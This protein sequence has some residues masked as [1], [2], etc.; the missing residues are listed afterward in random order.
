MKFTTKLNPGNLCRLPR[1]YQTWG[2]YETCRCCQQSSN[3]GYV[4]AVGSWDVQASSGCG[5]HQQGIANYPEHHSLLERL[6]SRLNGL[7]HLLPWKHQHE[8]GEVYQGDGAIVH[9]GDSS[10]PF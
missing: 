3:E 4:H 10:L 6:Q 7:A 1:F 9:S 2:K 5:C 8:E